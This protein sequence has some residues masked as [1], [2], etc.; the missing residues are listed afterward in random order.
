MYDIKAGKGVVSEL[1]FYQNLQILATA[2]QNTL[3]IY[4]VYGSNILP[5]LRSKSDNFDEESKFGRNP[6]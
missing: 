3:T 6:M 1:H 2:W 4:A 5:A